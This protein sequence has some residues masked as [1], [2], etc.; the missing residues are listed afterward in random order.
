MMEAISAKNQLKK[1]ASVTIEYL[2]ETIKALQSDTID[3]K[4]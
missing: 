1:R 3:L 4:A 2:E